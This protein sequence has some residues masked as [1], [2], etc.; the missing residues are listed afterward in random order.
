MNESEMMAIAMPGGTI[1]HHFST[2]CCASRSIFPHD[3]TFGSN[4]PRKLSAAS[5]II[6]LGTDVASV[7]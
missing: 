1:H 2:Y 5:E 6:A 3:I 7:T 4:K